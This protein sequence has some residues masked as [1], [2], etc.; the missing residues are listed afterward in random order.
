ME[1]FR[2]LIPCFF[3]VLKNFATVRLH[4]LFGSK[5]IIDLFKEIK[6]VSRY[7]LEFVL[8]IYKLNIYEKY[9]L[10]INAGIK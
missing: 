10:R 5:L 4:L 6:I 7:L 3:L 9:E 2:E 8:L 1:G